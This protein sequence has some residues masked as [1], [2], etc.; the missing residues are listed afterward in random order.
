MCLGKCPR[1]FL[2]EDTLVGGF[3]SSRGDGRNLEGCKL[4]L[5]EVQREGL[6]Q[7][8]RSC[9]VGFRVSRE[10]HGGVGGQRGGQGGQVGGDG[11]VG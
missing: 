10:G 1:V 8:R 11:G 6:F 2:G 4:E 3:F 5:V 7:G 9:W